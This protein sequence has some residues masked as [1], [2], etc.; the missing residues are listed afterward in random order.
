MRVKVIENIEDKLNRLPKGYIFTYVDFLQ[1]VGEKEAIIKAL[2]RMVKEGKIAKLSR[3]KYYKPQLSQFGQLLP[4]PSQIVKDL[5]EKNGKI[6][7]YLTGY[8]IFSKLGFTTQVSNIIQIGSNQIRSSFKRGFYTITFVRQKNTINRENIPLLQ[9][10]DV[11]RFI[12]KI[13]DA[14]VEESCLRLMTLIK[15]LPEE[16]KHRMVKLALKYPPFARA[17]LGA[18]LEEI[19]CNVDTTALYAS[20]NPITKYKIPGA[21]NVLKSASKW[22]IV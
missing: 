4:D 22:N 17:L 15:V 19:K 20:L 21:A 11:V 6:T 8:S 12:K 16:D 14:T 5:L 18:L 10:L 2:N 13:P 3:G 9:L 7:G 1:D